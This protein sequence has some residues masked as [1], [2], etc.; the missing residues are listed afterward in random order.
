[1]K[2][3]RLGN[4]AIGA[5]LLSVFTTPSG[6]TTSSFTGD[7][8]TDATFTDCGSGCTLGA[9]N[10]DGDYAQY[11][12]VVRSFTVSTLSAMQAL[13]FSYGGGTNGN[14]DSILEGGFQPYLSLFDNSGNFIASTYFGTACYAGANTNSS[15]GQCFDVL[16][17][18]G[19]LGPATYQIAI[20]AYFNQSFAENL[21]SGTLSDGFTGLG[22]LFF[23]ED[24]H[25]AFD[26][27]LTD[28]TPVP[29]PRIISIVALAVL[30]F[31]GLLFRLSAFGSSHVF[32]DGINHRT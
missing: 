17:D 18:G 23:G 8:R 24:L 32:G 25:Y 2:R 31:F 11:A 12:A 1:V 26:V 13:T 21:G 30:F 28:A 15:S 3:I 4:L 20:S 22:N 10:S 16:L 6:A 27:V 9:G 5:L 7:L 19:V 29:E 14:G